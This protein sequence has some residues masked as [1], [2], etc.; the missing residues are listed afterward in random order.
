[1]ELARYRRWLPCAALV[2]AALA[3]AVLTAVLIPARIGLTSSRSGGQ[4]LPAG[5]RPAP[6]PQNQHAEVSAAGRSHRVR[7]H[8][9]RSTAAPPP[10]DTRGDLDNGVVRSVFASAPMELPIAAPDPAPLPPEPAPAPAPLATPSIFTLPEPPP[11]PEPVRVAPEPPNVG[12][13]VSDAA[14][15]ANSE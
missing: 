10:S 6:V 1:M 4:D 12:I 7:S 9:V 5:E 2:G 13:P 15:E 3:Q 11:A 8:R 14:P